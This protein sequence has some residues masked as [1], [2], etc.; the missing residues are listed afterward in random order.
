MG[1]IFR[2]PGR[3]PGFLGQTYVPWSAS[4]LPSIT[5]LTPNAGRPVGGT[6]ITINGSGFAAGAVVLIGG[7][8]AQ[9][10]VVVNSNQITAVTPPHDEGLVSVTVQNLDGNSFTLDNAF[11]YY[12]PAILYIDPDWSD[13]G[14]GRQAVIT[15][16]NFVTGS[17]ITF[18]GV[19]ATN[20]V[21]VDSQHY[22]LQIPPH[23][24]G[25][26]DVVITA[27][28]G[29]SA[30]LDSGFRY[31]EQ[32]RLQNIRR[33]PSISIQDRLNNAPNTC[34]FSVDGGALPPEVLQEV[35]FV[36][37]GYTVFAGT[38]Q[39]VT[40]EYEDDTKNVVWRVSCIDYTWRLNNRRPFGTYVNAS[41]SD[42]VIDLC[43][44]Y[45]PWVSTN[46]VQ[47]N[48]A[49][50]S[51]VFDG[52]SDFT[53]CL[54][55]L[56]QQ[57]GEGHWYL[58]Y[59]RDM[60]FFHMKKKT[61]P[62]LPGMPTNATPVLISSPLQVGPGTPMVVSESSTAVDS[63]EGFVPGWYV[64]ASASYYGKAIT[65][66]TPPGSFSPVAPGT[67][68]V[69]LS[70]QAAEAALT[71]QIAIGPASYPV[72]S[73]P[74]TGPP[75]G[76]S[77]RSLSEALQGW[78]QA[79]PGWQNGDTVSFKAT[80]TFL[81]GGETD[82]GS[83]FGSWVFTSSAQ[84]PGVGLIGAAV[85]CPS[86][87]NGASGVNLYAS[88]D[89]GATW[90][91]IANNLAA[92]QNFIMPYTLNPTRFDSLSGT[93]SSIPAIAGTNR[94]W[95]GYHSNGVQISQY[96]LF[97][98]LVAGDVFYATADLASYL[99]NMTTGQ[100][101]QSAF[102]PI[103]NAIYLTTKRPSFT[104][105][106]LA[107]AL[108][109]YVAKARR[110]YYY[111]YSDSHVGGK[112]W[113]G[114]NLINDNTTTG[115]IVLALSHTFDAP[116]VANV[117]PPFGPLTAPQFTQSSTLIDS[118]NAV[119][120]GPNPGYWAV[121][122]SGVYQDNTESYPSPASAAVLLDGLH[123]STIDQLPTFP[124]INGVP[125]VYRKIYASQVIPANPPLPGNPDFLPGHT[126]LVWIIIDNTSTGPINIQIGAGLTGGTG[127]LPVG[128][129]LLTGVADTPQNHVDG[130][131]LE[132]ELK[133]DDINDTNTDLLKDPPFVPTISVSQL[134]NRIIVKG[135]G[136][137]VT[138][139]AAVGDQKVYVGDVSMFN[140]SGP[141]QF[142]IGSR[143]L[144]YY[145][146]DATVGKANLILARPLVD[147]ILQG[148]WKYGGGTPIRPYVQLDDKDSQRRVGRVE[149]DRQGKPTDGVH[150]YT[151]DDN[152]LATTEQMIARGLT[153][154][155]LFS[156]PVVQITYATRDPK[157]RSGKI[158]HVDLSNPPCKGDFIIQSVD[159]NQFH[160]ESDTLSPRYIIR[161]DSAAR[162][163]L[164]D[165]LLD[166]SDSKD[167][168]ATGPTSM[169]GLVD[170]AISQSG[171]GSST[172]FP[173]RREQWCFIAPTTNTPVAIGAGCS[174]TL[175]SG[176][177]DDDEIPPWRDHRG[178]TS[179]GTWAVLTT[180]NTLN[181]EAK[182]LMGGGP[183]DLL[184]NNF[185]VWF[186]I[187]TPKSLSDIHISCGLHQLGSIPTAI[188]ALNLS[189]VSIRYASFVGNIDPGWVGVVQPDGSPQN[190]SS[191]YLTPIAPSTRYVM[192][193]RSVIP[194]GVDG[195]LSGRIEFTVNG[196][197]VVLNRV[198][199]AS[200]AG[201]QNPFNFPTARSA[202][203][204]S[205]GRFQCLVGVLQK[206]SNGPIR[207]L[208]VRRIYAVSD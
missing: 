151:I 163:D 50:V 130:P 45:H 150:E 10:V 69:Q 177:F 62:L 32:I 48:L 137:I 29:L 52:G 61:S 58:D 144:D 107:P 105:I 103:S 117:N 178:Q 181:N 7:N 72:T 26:V 155:Q 199:T 132:D 84:L 182:L 24:I 31:T 173:K 30:T 187:F 96:E 46:H 59:D 87:L 28:D 66:T 145:T 63:S 94:G 99:E 75:T 60:H 154:L 205:P 102:S 195:Y 95:V 70:D 172:D 146:V 90:H 78:G 76:G 129:P 131:W 171:F 192:R 15:G 38:V 127:D 100:F 165:L 56:A 86:Q 21:F 159:I 88:R 115:P 43:T 106:P 123:Q 176:L 135:K 92:G 141:G 188:P 57:L 134:R 97:G 55:Y 174:P 17:T 68:M 54:S 198:S 79:I 156:N 23:A 190:E 149:L 148:D 183:Y 113:S 168:R 207:K 153:E 119:P 160:D 194:S 9:S 128:T 204:N 180:N 124:S 116:V 166:L 36:D 157:P 20:L 33:V 189:L 4:G 25:S 89:A 111:R 51:V 42:V 136:T 41:I 104:N 34:H 18:G 184:E 140:T 37:R 16:Q 179:N 185:D 13:L 125:C 170:A 67:G 193:I 120:L 162:Y 164:N 110:I 196:T 83:V 81:N 203:D 175:T 47:T 73:T 85:I 147:P 14:G 197:T 39:D 2:K 91:R 108:T 35:S 44:R 74:D 80:G 53:T 65:F 112:G 158:V 27:P 202:T 101:I 191:V 133:P 139:D 5:Y 122:I 77:V 22:A 208:S 118:T 186:E 152:D 114:F 19:A 1:R 64:F 201:S 121:K 126:N 40:Q 12:S 6:A 109:G 142:I 3:G 8:N 49:R 11:T 161:A 138:K 200:A 98:H 206:K 82:F 169:V 167:S 143:V 93:R 71:G